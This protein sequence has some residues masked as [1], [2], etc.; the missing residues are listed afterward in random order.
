[1]NQEI[2]HHYILHHI[3]KRGNWR[4]LVR[5]VRF[6]KDEI[7]LE[8]ARDIVRNNEVRLR[9]WK[10][11]MWLHNNSSS[12]YGTILNHSNFVECII[13]HHVNKEIWRFY[14]SGQFVHRFSFREDWPTNTK[15][16]DALNALYRITEIFRF[17]ASVVSKYKMFDAGVTI[18]IGLYDLLNRKLVTPEPDS[19]IFG[20][21]KCH[22]EYLQ[23][24]DNYTKEKL[25][26]TSVEQALDFALYF[27]TRFNWLNP[28]LK[29]LLREEQQNLIRGASWSY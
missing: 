19:L 25:V 10:Y 7:S 9:S 14:Q 4:V 27:F 2:D 8:K 22:E 17:A 24:G 11:P 15:T 13:D 16:F 3:L 18:R 29:H 1:M 23:F 20:E 12:G 26:G 28:E 6:N 5:P 21:Y